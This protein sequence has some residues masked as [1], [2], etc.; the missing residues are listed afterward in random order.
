[1][2]LF[3]GMMLEKRRDVGLFSMTLTEIGIMRAFQGIFGDPLF[4]PSWWRPSTF[5][6]KIG[7]QL[8]NAK[9]TLQDLICRNVKG[10]CPTVSFTVPDEGHID[11]HSHDRNIY[12]SDDYLLVQWLLGFIFYCKYATLHG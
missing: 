9:V 4:S 1:M 12:Y 11:L 5:G 7:W 2:E 10:R 8:V 6:G 3:S